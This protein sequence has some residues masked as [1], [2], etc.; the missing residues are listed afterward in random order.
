MTERSSEGLD[1]RRRRLLFR[2]WHRGIKEVDLVL[3]GY[4]DAR[5]GAMSEAELDQFEAVLEIPTPDLLSWLMGE[6]PVPAEHNSPVM[7]QM[8]SFHLRE[9]ARE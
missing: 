4:A 6:Q 1:E 7:R 8:L 3:G 2:S 9:K 5:I